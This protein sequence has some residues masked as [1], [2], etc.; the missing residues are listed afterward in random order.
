MIRRAFNEDKACVIA[1]LEQNEAMN[2]PMIAQINRFGF[3]KDFQDIWLYQNDENQIQGV[4]LR[5]FNQMYLH[6]VM[7]DADYEEIASFSSFLSADMI[8]S[9]ES[10]LTA[11]Q[12]FLEAFELN[13]SR[14]MVLE[15]TQCLY[16]DHEVEEAGPEDCARLAAMIYENEEFRQFYASEEEIRKGIGRRM[17]LGQCRYRVLRQDGMIVSQAY[18]TM[19]TANFATIGGVI[20][21]KAYQ[22]RGFAG[23]VVSAL[24]RDIFKSGKKPNLFYHDETAGR[25]YKRLGFTDVGGYGVLRSMGFNVS[26]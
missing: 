1:L 24:A 6:E 22:N 4:I 16:E 10:S 11:M 25:L 5:H 18:T 7:Q 21:D 9:D 14:H 12:P 23:K 19:E 2:C 13:A 17:A 3:D 26:F 15:H 20:T 8:W